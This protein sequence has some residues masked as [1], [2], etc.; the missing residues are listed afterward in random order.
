MKVEP[1]NRGWGCSM[2][3]LTAHLVVFPRP[4]QFLH[5]DYSTYFGSFGRHNCSSDQDEFDASKII[6]FRTNRWNMFVLSRWKGG[7]GG[8][9]DTGVGC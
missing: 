6:D 7:K 3:W 9:Y 8:E 5:I 1:S 4:N 2:R